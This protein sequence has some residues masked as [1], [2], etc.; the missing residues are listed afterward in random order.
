MVDTSGNA[1]THISI[2]P[3]NSNHFPLLY[4]F[5]A[6]TVHYYVSTLVNTVMSPSLHLTLYLHIHDHEHT[7]LLLLLLPLR[8]TYY[9]LLFILLL[10]LTHALLFLCVCFFCCVCVPLLSLLLLLLVSFLLPVLLLRWFVVGVGVVVVIVII[11]VAVVVVVA[12]IVGVVVFVRS[13]CSTSSCIINIH[14]HITRSPTCHI[15][16]LCG[17]EL[18]GNCQR[19]YNCSSPIPYYHASAIQRLCHTT[20]L[21]IP[22]YYS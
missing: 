14:A 3:P 9:L 11:I 16:Y 22:L 12:V 20:P 7:V 6:L 18:I 13:M 15:A 19:V 2:I 1:M 4:V 5:N 8:L 10:L 17:T 21:S